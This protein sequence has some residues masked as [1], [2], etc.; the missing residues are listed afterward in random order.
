MPCSS[1]RLL[2]SLSAKVRAAQMLRSRLQGGYSRIMSKCKVVD[3]SSMS[4]EEQ[5][6]AMEQHA[7]GPKMGNP[8]PPSLPP[9]PVT[10]VAPAA[11]PPHDSSKH[12]SLFEG[13][14]KGFLEGASLGG[15][16]GGE[17]D[18]VVF[19]SLCAGVD[20]DFSDLAKSSSKDD[21]ESDAFLGPLGE[22]AK[23]LSGAGAMGA[24]QQPAGAAAAEHLP[25]KMRETVG[26]IDGEVRPQRKLVSSANLTSLSCP[27]S[28]PCGPALPLS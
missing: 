7:G 3:M 5:K 4:P 13:M 19:D 25:V 20:P 10:K 23:V 6:L 18:D 26:G 28:G 17:S 12:P 21:G 2:P 9:P 1:R 15:R 8:L 24:M 27:S 16:G 22:I 14:G 11:A